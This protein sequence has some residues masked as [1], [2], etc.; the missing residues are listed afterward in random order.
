MIKMIDISK[1]KNVE[2]VATAIGE[3][4]LKKTTIQKIRTKKV[5]KGDV[6][7]TAHIAG[8]QAVKNTPSIIPLCHSMPITNIDIN[9][10]L[11]NDKIICRCTVNAFYKTGVEMESLTGV[12]AA[13]LSIWDMVKYLEKDKN[14]QYLNTTISNI[15]IVEKQKG[16]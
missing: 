6:L 8:I 4:L 1:K 3:I 2:R 16:E 9:F 14:G 11:K 13:L 5:E 15:K 7:T 10:G 12:C